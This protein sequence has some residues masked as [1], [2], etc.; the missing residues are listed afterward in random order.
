MNM[1]S[2]SEARQTVGFLD[3][4]GARLSQS[5]RRLSSGVKVEK[6]GDAGGLAVSS[7]LES[8]VTR[9]LAIAENV[10]NGVSFPRGS[11]C[12]PEQAR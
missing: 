11:G 8:A 3:N 6:G 12:R 4:A 5:L 2:F 7:K 10:Q 1:H 9:I